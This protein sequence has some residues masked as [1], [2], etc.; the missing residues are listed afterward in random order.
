V[1]Q[2][3]S[4]EYSV[5]RMEAARQVLNLANSNARGQSGSEGYDQSTAFGRN[6]AVSQAM[7]FSKSLED[8]YGF[9]ETQATELAASI[10]AGVGTPK[11]LEKLFSFNA[12]GRG[13]AS[14]KADKAKQASDIQNLAN[15]MGITNSLDESVRNMK[16]SK[17]SDSHSR[18]ARFAQDIGHTMERAENTREAMSKTQQAI[19]SYSK[20]QSFSKTG[21]FNIDRDES[22]ELLEFTA[23]QTLQGRCI[24]ADGAYRLLN[25]GGYQ[26][27]AIVSAFREQKWEGI[28]SQIDGGLSIKT[29]EDLNALYRNASLPGKA[30]HSHVDQAVGKVS[31]ETLTQQASSQ[32]LIDPIR[33]T[34]KG[35]YEQQK[36]HVHNEISRTG[37][38]ISG[39]EKAMEKKTDQTMN[40][41]LVGATI[42]NAG[43]GLIS[44]I[45]GTVSSA[46][47]APETLSKLDD[48]P[49]FQSNFKRPDDKLLPEEVL[50]QQT[51]SSHLPSHKRKDTGSTI[52][53]TDFQKAKE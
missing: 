41:S 7:R 46:Y 37:G 45:E 11:I 44:G 47:K 8:R 19:D 32:G 18:E 22:Q 6:T 27:D 21:A 38:Y 30:V 53:Q 9:N 16:D 13:T 49:K 52:K 26:A 23:N 31:G 2:A 48:P 24:G 28:K 35:A 20:L 4:E 29:E 33:S 10:M 51:S 1:L 34:T 43:E 42:F 25:T 40:R 12:E 39:Q 14:T 5:A 50:L 17:F 15:E 36:E 3:Q